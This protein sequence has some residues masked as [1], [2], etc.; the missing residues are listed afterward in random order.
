MQKQR[1]KDLLFFDQ[2]QCFSLL[3]LKWYKLITGVKKI[4]QSEGKE[5]ALCS[6][7]ILKQR[8]HLWMKKKPRC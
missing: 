1:K 6:S 7:G 4:A 2:K 3:L 8:K 5:L